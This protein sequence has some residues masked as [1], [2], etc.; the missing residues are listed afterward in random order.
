MLIYFL[1]VIYRYYDSKVETTQQWVE[2][3]YG[4]SQGMKKIPP[5]PPPRAVT[6]VLTS[7]PRR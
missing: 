2:D 4:G 1:F 5:P 3:H 7:V 6:T